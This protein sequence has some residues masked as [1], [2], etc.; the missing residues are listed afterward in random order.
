[1]NGGAD[2]SV[3]R[4]RAHCREVEARGMHGSAAHCA[5][6]TMD[7][8][9][10]ME[11]APG[12][13]TTF[14]G[15]R[16]L[17]FG[18]TSYLGLASHPE[19][20]RAGCEAMQRYGVHSATSRTWLGT[21]PALVAVERE[22]ALFFGTEDA[23]CLSS[24]Y[25]TNL[26]L[27]SVMARGARAV[28]VDDACHYS[29][30]DAAKATRLPVETVAHHD[31][32]DLGKR[33]RQH[34]PCVILADGVHPATGEVAPVQALLDL[35]GEGDHRILFDD[36][37]GFG[38]LG[39]NGRGVLE[40]FGRWSG[41]NAVGDTPG[42]GCRTAVGGTLAKALGGF[43]GIIPG[44]R[45]FLEDLRR[46]SHLVSGS[47]APAAALA[48][49]SARALE[50]A[51]REP[52]RRVQLERNAR[53]LREGLAALGIPTPAGRSAHVGVRLGTRDNM[54]R[55]HLE[56]RRRGI[57]VPHLDAYSGLPQ[58]GVV[59]IAVFATHTTDQIQHL[60]DALRTLL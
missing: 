48:G 32:D 52:E 51:R 43:G 8:P 5:E 53:H 37:H 31:P 19:V 42:G 3:R 24:G 54:R 30:Q 50:M 38:V 2:R 36:A 27:M 6:R 57:M 40:E 34:G 16:Y 56:L 7:R 46:T 13:E 58:G 26:C 28:L 20:L 9:P 59:R 44:S 21:N 25:L 23:L 55:I 47:S 33:L 10:L 60:L 22:A 14:D 18:G 49:A 12:P 4:R 39:T 29:A 1:M 35:V 41:V 15:V 17:Y 45:A 11:S